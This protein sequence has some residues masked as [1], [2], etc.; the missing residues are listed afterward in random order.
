MYTIILAFP[1]NVK[2][3]GRKKHRH[4]GGQCQ[5]DLLTLPIQVALCVLL[6]NV[7]F[8]PFKE[9]IAVHCTGG[10]MENRGNQIFIFVGRI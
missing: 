7:C 4:P 10:H 3:A 2:R 1:K 6:F 8:E 9:R 5:V